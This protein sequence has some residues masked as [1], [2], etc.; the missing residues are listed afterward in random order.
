MANWTLEL[1]SGA[2]ESFLFLRWLMI[3]FEAIDRQQTSPAVHFVANLFVSVTPWMRQCKTMYCNCIL[4]KSFTHNIELSQAMSD[5]SG[6]RNV[7][8]RGEVV[9]VSKDVSNQSWSLLWN[10]FIGELQSYWNLLGLESRFSY[11][12]ATTKQNNSSAQHF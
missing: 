10:V 9:V 11:L 2:S 4:L 1:R 3:I 5:L 7:S 8:V 12:Q 6:L